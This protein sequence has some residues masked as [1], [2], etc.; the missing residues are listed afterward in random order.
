[1]RAW[2]TSRVLCLSGCKM[3]WSKVRGVTGVMIG[4]DVTL[5]RKRCRTW[6]E[7]KISYENYM[8]IFEMVNFMICV[9]CHSFKIKNTFLKSYGKN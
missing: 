5:P 7:R 4:M 2:R 9:F 3:G 8:Y 1:M 6:W